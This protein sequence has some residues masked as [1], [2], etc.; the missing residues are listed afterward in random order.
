VVLLIKPLAADIAS[1]TEPRPASPVR[2]VL[3]RRNFRLLWGGQAISL[4]GDQFFLIALP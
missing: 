2:R 1:G 3:G 4:L